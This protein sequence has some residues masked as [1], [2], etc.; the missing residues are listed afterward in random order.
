ML[1]LLHN[2]FVL[3]VP[4]QRAPYISWYC[5][6]DTYWAGW[7]HCKCYG[8]LGDVRDFV[9]SMKYTYYYMHIIDVF[10]F[11][12]CIS[13]C[14]NISKFLM[15][16]NY[17][18]LFHPNFLTTLLLWSS[19]FCVNVLP[20][21]CWMYG[22]GHWTGEMSLKYAFIACCY[23]YKH[24]EAKNL[25]TMHSAGW[26]GPFADICMDFEKLLVCFYDT[27]CCCYHI[28]LH[29]WIFFNPYFNFPDFWKEHEGP[30]QRIHVTIYALVMN[31]IWRCTSGRGLAIEIY[32]FHT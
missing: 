23:Q 8:Q 14:I 12:T 28:N 30:P 25:H 1:R 19:S 24:Q 10:Q 16:R 26:G 18:R 4:P 9:H 7:Y 21:R 6:Y 22:N 5:H 17:I 2:N 20:H 31:G 27:C 29:E 15:C 13:R 3:C 32:D 11:V